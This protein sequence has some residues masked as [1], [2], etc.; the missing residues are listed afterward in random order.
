[1]EIKNSGFEKNPFLEKI[2][3]IS[4]ASDLQIKRL[5]EF[6]SSLLK[7]NQELNLIGKST[8]SN[9][10]ERHI[11]DSAQLIPL[12]KNKKAK[13]VDFGSGAGFPGIVLSILGLEEIHLVEKSFRKAKFL[14]MAKNFSENK[15]LVHPILLEEIRIFDFEI[16]VSRALAS[17]DKLLNHS[18]HFLKND[19]YCLFLKGKSLNKEIEEALKSFSFEYQLI[20]SITSKESNII[21]VANIKKLIF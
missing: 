16:I 6:V 1:M 20:P 13:T 17:L 12:I 3:S 4:E 9:I 10:W 19:G 5:E 21:K 15:I 14:G 8:I 11:L 7:N 2:I 18:I